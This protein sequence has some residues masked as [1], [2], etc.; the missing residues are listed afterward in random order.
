MF[1]RHIQPSFAGGE[2]SPSLQARVD[3][4]AYH[5][6]L[7]T[8]RNFFVHP[9]GGA[10]NR[11]GTAY[12][13]TAKNTGKSC[14][15]VP[16][17]VGE[18]EA[19]VLEL[20]HHYIRVYT[21]AGQVL[22]DGGES[23]YEISS[24][25]V[26]ADLAEVCYTQYDQK[27]FLAHPDYPPQC[28]T[29][30]SP[31]RFSLEEHPVQFGP[32]MLSNTQDSRKM[33][34]YSTQE[35]SQVQGVAATLSF[36]PVVDNRY[37]VYGYFNDVLFSVAR[38]YGLDLG[39]LVSDF[40]TKF[41]SSGVTAVNLGGV[42]KITSPQA[43][44]GDWNGAVLRL[45]YRDSFLHEPSIV[46][47][48]VLSGG[49]N[50]GGTVPVGNLTYVLESNF[51]IFSPKHETGR[52]SLTHVLPSQYQTGTL[53]YDTS[54]GVIKSSSDWRIQTS[55]TWTGTL[56][57]EKSE[58]LGVTWQAVKYFIRTSNDNNFVEFGTL[59]DNGKIYHLRLRAVGITGQA[60][61]EL[62]AA[63]FKQE[64]VAVVEHF[65]DA[66]HV[67][68][69]LERPYGAADWTSDWAEGSFSPKNGYPTCVFFYQDRLGLA[70][71]YQEPQTL[72]FSKTGLYGD[73]GHARGE[74]LDTDAMSINLSGKK[75]NTIHNVSA[76]GK[77]LIFTAG[78]EWSLS[79]NG[80][81]T[82]YN[83]QIEQQSERGSSATSVVVVGNRALYVQARG[84]ALRD[85]YY[86]YASAS[87]TGEDLTLCAKHLFHNKTIT[88]ICHQQE[89]DNLIWCVL[90]DGG[91]ATL[92]YVAEQNICAW[93]HHDTQG[94]FR[95]VCTIPN[96][97][98]DEVWFVVE[99]GNNYFIEKL[100][101]R[102]ASTA[103][104]DQVFLDASI[105]KKSDTAFSEV[106]G[107][108][109]LEGKSVGV[110]A[111]G[112]PVSGL[113][114]HEGKITLPRPMTSVHVGLLYRAELQTLPIV[115]QLEN[116]FSSDQKKRVVSV[117]LQLANS[118]GGCVG[119]DGERA[120]E[121]IQRQG[122]PYNT[123]LDLKTESYVL[124]LS[125]THTLMP[126]VVFTQEQ[127]LPV[128]LLALL[129]RVA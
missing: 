87:Y 1:T 45:T 108:T 98:Y 33:R 129:C 65:I 48:Q 32:F 38:D 2:V 105:S 20:G 120:E 29:R 110:L 81:L 72:W 22:A 13:G 54:S 8:A 53:G 68:V 63:A 67:T 111:D 5:T 91:L 128:T 19:Y 50:D 102:L 40:N 123:P 23:V 57:L 76:A 7:K 82:P 93:T 107:L 89:P 39:V 78:S 73:F 26:A 64:G 83:V 59:E 69:T 44:G 109:H 43:T 117:T 55:G 94:A 60:G 66:Q 95:S 4:A 35:T 119:L 61:Y 70:G 90:S 10:S 118:R 58:D 30:L 36:A 126:S 11:P 100:L 113:T 75:L 96:R 116:G 101:P 71:T 28:L 12:M 17:V 114:V 127:P 99:R 115:F 21:S 80:A 49:V 41:S 51:D 122:E 47:E 16:F 88:E 27:L 85:F 15:I 121:I 86:D 103:P 52:F 46:I 125:G 42:L 104:Q 31:G 106:T 74:L 25:Y 9:Q 84:R 77:L 79:S 124:S 24:P 6:W 14:R 18:N 34:I 62:T 92:T 97:G 56:V 112:N 3:T 37:F